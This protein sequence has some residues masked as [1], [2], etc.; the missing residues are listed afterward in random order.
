MCFDISC[1]IY[2]YW[3][4]HIAK[5][6]F[7]SIHQYWTLTPELIM[8][9]PFSPLSPCNVPSLNIYLFSSLLNWSHSEHLQFPF[10]CEAIRS[11]SLVVS[12]KS[13]KLIL[14]QF[15][16]RPSALGHPSLKCWYSPVMSLSLALQRDLVLAQ[17]EGTDTVLP[18]YCF[19]Q[20]T[21]SSRYTNHRRGLV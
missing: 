11:F 1:L 3:N 10:L 6:I 21:S 19:L 20:G 12:M 18:T 7:Q 17:R 15:L 2:I 4:L 14:I 13:N 5:H 8:F 9:L 16:L